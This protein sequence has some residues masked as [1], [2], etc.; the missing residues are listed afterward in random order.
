[1]LFTPSLLGKGASRQYC[2]TAD[3]AVTSSA[4][5]VNSIGFGNAGDGL[6]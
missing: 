5:V 4:G 1:M 3:D 6:G 2:C